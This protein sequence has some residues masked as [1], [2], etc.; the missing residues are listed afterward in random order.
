M[1]YIC[2]VFHE[3]GNSSPA[4]FFPSLTF[5]VPAQVDGVSGIAVLSKVIEKMHIPAHSCV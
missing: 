3:F 5:A 4:Q 2:N 1:N